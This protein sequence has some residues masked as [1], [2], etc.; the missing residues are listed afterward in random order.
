M[1]SSRKKG[2]A[3]KHDA[4]D[5]PDATIHGELL[6]RVKNNELPCAVAF[7][8]AGDLSATPGDVGRTMDLMNARLTK[9]QLGLFGYAPEKKIVS[10]R[11]PDNPE[12][13]AALQAALVD[14]RLPC[15]SAWEI[16]DRFGVR[17]LVV[18]A[19]CEALGIKIKPCQLGA[20]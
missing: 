12:M 17:K 2:F 13:T 4:S 14:H 15:A 18:S 1:D 3:E 5:T 7:Q 8:V 20:F 11:M 6:T 9:C 16:A 19:A 10:S